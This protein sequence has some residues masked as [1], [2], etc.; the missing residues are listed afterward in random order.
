MSRIERFGMNFFIDDDPLDSELWKVLEPLIKRKRGAQ[1][2]KAVLA[3]TLLAG[4]PLQ[5]TPF[6]PIVEPPSGRAGNEAIPVPIAIDA[7]ADDVA[8]INFLSTFG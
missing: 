4:G 8:A 7:Q 3:R 5:M 1:T 6:Q 2:I